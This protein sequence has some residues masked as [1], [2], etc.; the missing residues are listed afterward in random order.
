M[1]LDDIAP[2]II[3]FVDRYIDQFV[4]W[5][6]LAY[7]HEN[8]D[9]ERK[10]TGVALDIGRRQATIEPVLKS[11][12]KKGVLEADIDETGDPNYTYVAPAE[13]RKS[14]DEFLTAARDRTNR[15]AI[16]GKVLQKEARRL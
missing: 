4:D 14:M 16:V 5:D 2:E 15:L 9:V 3:E 1:P 11:L 10:A 8:P 13:F 7:F 6:V 12:V